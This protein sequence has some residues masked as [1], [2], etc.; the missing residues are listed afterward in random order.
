MI[1]F[2]PRPCRIDK[3]GGNRLGFASPSRSVAGFQTGVYTPAGLTNPAGYGF[4]F[5]N[6]GFQT[7]VH[8][9]AGLTNPVGNWSGF[10]NPGFQTGVYNE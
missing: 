1:V 10:V 7:G 9:P 8:A 6:P 5:V 3:S 2:H 4:G